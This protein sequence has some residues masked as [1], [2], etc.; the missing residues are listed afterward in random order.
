MDISIEPLGKSISELLSMLQET[1]IFPWTFL[2]KSIL[3]SLSVTGYMEI[4]MYPL[5]KNIFELFSFLQ[6]T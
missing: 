1:W 2:V 5:G 3:I 4:S 6:D